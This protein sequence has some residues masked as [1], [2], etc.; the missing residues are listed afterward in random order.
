MHS[1]AGAVTQWMNAM[2][3]SVSTGAPAW[4]DVF[5]TF[6]R[7]GVLSFGG[8]AAQIALMHRVLV[9][10]KRWL[11][12][13]QYL[14]A[15]S[16]CMLLPGPEAMQL[17][18]YSGWRLRG[19]TG[20][21]LAGLLF[22]IPGA[23][24]VLGLAILYGLFGETPL[25]A[26]LFLGIKAAVLVIVVEALL[27]VARRA[28]HRLTGWIIAGAAFGGIFLF[29][30]PFPL[31]IVA[32]AVVGFSLRPGQAGAHEAGSTAPALISLRSTAQTL[33]LWL[34]IWWAPLL[35]LDLLS[36]A[37][38]LATIGYFFSKL[39]VVTFGGAYAVLAYMAQQVVTGFGWLSAG[40][41]LDGLGLAETTP[42][43]LILVTEFVGFLAAFR[44]GGLWLGL[45]GAV[46]TLWATFAPC[47]LWIFA[48]APYIEWI[49]SQPRLR[50]ALSAITASVVGVILNLS[51][52]FA[53][54]VMF[55][56]VTR[57]TVGPLTLWQPELASID[58]RVLVLS[59][60]SAVLLL[61]LHWGIGRVLAISAATGWV[62]VELQ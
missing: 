16:F 11:S 60:L 3:E 26:T 39:A 13:R 30:I 17:A 22:V 18:T 53:L 42:G 46:V 51:I 38:V 47:F 44:T 40:E 27:R 7:I 5:R 14:D 29:E 34:F 10:E 41:M 33:L 23:C 37:P 50:G 55:A 4:P 15:L 56:N 43:P 49:S 61:R 2:T 54:H 59:L 52:W 1:I 25:L 35:L 48:G 28:L 62:L 21:L 58:W 45:A 19:V 9:E 36:A 8:P 32:A 31:I 20:G 6:G 57:Q 12:E 24:V